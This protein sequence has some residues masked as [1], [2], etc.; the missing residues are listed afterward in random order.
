MRTFRQ[1]FGEQPQLG[2]EV[3]FDVAMIVE[4]IA[5]E[6]GEEAGAEVERIDAALGDPD[7]GNFGECVTHALALHLREAG[8]E[9]NR[10]RASSGRDKFF[11]SPHEN[12]DGAEDPRGTPRGLE[13]RAQK[14]VVVVLPLVPVIP[15]RF[16]AGAGRAEKA[17][18]SHAHQEPWLRRIDRC[19]RRRFSSG[20]V[21]RRARLSFPP[22]LHPPL[23]HAPRGLMH[24]LYWPACAP[25]RGP[26]RRTNARAEPRASRS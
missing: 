16:D 8:F 5:A 15:M 10:L 26:A 20:N 6:I 4:M 22:S 11:R 24:H 9:I 17:R 19:S 2:S 12:S 18:R 14:Y 3:I 21:F 1:N 25:H 13:N 23:P 7:R